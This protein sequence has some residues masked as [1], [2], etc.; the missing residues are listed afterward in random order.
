M[1]RIRE[2]HLVEHTE[3]VDALG[4]QPCLL[5]CLAQGRRDRSVVRRVDPP[6]GKGDLAG[7][8]PEGRR[9]CQQEHV[10]ISRDRRVPSIPIARQIIEDAEEHQHC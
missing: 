1:T 5:A 10:E 9:A 3:H 6:A 2:G 7:M 4:V 8:R